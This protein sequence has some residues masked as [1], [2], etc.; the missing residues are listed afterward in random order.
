M[1]FCNKENYCKRENATWNWLS[2]G[3][4]GPRGMRPP[5]GS[6]KRSILEEKGLILGRKDGCPPLYKKNL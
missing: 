3:S 4:R 1:H 2:S 5:F 6:K